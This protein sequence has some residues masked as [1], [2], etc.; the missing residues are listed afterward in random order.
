MTMHWGTRLCTPY[1]RSTAQNNSLCRYMWLAL[2]HCT[3]ACMGFVLRFTLS[4]QVPKVRNGATSGVFFLC[5]IAV[6]STIGVDYVLRRC[7][8][9]Y[10]AKLGRQQ[11]GHGVCG[12]PHLLRLHDWLALFWAAYHAG[13]RNN[14]TSVPAPLASFA[15]MAIIIFNLFFG[16]S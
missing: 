8:W 16:K 5:K 1:I 10:L 13:R 4:S 3:D 15:C 11:H 14:T 9:I 2:T 12:H 6:H 7:T